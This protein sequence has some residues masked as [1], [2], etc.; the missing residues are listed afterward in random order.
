MSTRPAPPSRDPDAQG[1]FQRSQRPLQAL[2]LLLPL[3]IAY[4]AGAI[5]FAAD[6]ETGQASHIVARSQLADF[7]SLFGATGYYLPGLLVVV[8][9]LTWHVLRRDPWQLEWKLY[10]AMAVESLALAIPILV[11]A[12]A[13]GREPL[14]NGE[15]YS[16]P[17]QLI[18]SIGAGIY[19]EL[20]FRLM[21]I[22]V[23]HLLLVDLVGLKHSTGAVLAVL[24]SSVLFAAYHFDSQASFEWLKFIFYFAAGVY[25]AWIYILRGFGIVAATHAFYDILIVA[26]MH[27]VI[28]LQ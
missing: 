1:Y 19:E 2:I 8:I 10:I 21:A 3:L 6:P 18:F 16:A 5:R 23:L 12:L 24:C 11:F 27:R 7:L 13:W 20:V 25:L 4:E 26:I 9:L 15:T 22:A 28:P 14:A 17:A